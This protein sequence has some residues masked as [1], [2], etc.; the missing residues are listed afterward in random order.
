MSPCFSI[1]DLGYRKSVNSEYYPQVTGSPATFCRRSY[2]V[3]IFLAEFG[4]TTVHS[5]SGNVSAL[6]HAVFVVVGDC[7]QKQ[8]IR[9]DARRVIAMMANAFPIGNRSNVYCPR[10]PVGKPY[11]I[12]YTESTVSEIAATSRPWPTNRGAPFINLLPESLFHCLHFCHGRL[13]FWVLP[14][15]PVSA[16]IRVDGQSRSL[17]CSVTIW[18]NNLSR[19]LTAGFSTGVP[20]EPPIT[21]P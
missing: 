15:L 16:R 20:F 12:V 4:I 10:C 11:T 2:V 9:I 6:F 8:M 21:W 5:F 3:D 14:R 17:T 19:T 7:S 1:N 13:A 18:R